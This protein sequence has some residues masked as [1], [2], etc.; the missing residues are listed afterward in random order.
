MMEKISYMRLGLNTIQAVDSQFN[1]ML[2]PV[3]PL[4]KP[5]EALQSNYGMTTIKGVTPHT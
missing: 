5:S 2:D 1:I 4:R 3:G